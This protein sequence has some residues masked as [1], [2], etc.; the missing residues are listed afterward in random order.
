MNEGNKIDIGRII[1]AEIYGAGDVDI[2]GKSK[3]TQ[4][5]I[6]FP[7]LITKLCRYEGVV[8]LA[9]DEMAVGDKLDIN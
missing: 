9:S 7:C 6:P 3:S 2:K 8:E 1:K 4:K 5:I